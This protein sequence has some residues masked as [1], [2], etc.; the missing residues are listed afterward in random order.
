MSRFKLVASLLKQGMTEI[1]RR[2]GLSKLD[3]LTIHGRDLIWGWLQGSTLVSFPSFVFGL[4]SDLFFHRFAPELIPQLVSQGNLDQFTD[5][6]AILKCSEENALSK[7]L[8]LISVYST[9]RRIDGQKFDATNFITRELGSEKFCAI[10]KEHDLVAIAFSCLNDAADAPRLL[11]K[12]R[13]P[14]KTESLVR[15]I[16]SIG[17]NQVSLAR[18][19]W[20]ITLERLLTIYLQLDT[21]LVHVS[22]SSL[23]VMTRDLLRTLA[24]GISIQKEQAIRKL[25]LLRCLYAGQWV[26]GYLPLLLLRGLSSILLISE[27]RNLVSISRELLEVICDA[28]PGINNRIGYRTIFES[29]VI[30]IWAVRDAHTDLSTLKNALSQ[31]EYKYTHE[32]VLGLQDLMVLCDVESSSKS[33]SRLKTIIRLIHHASDVFSPGEQA[34]STEPRR[35]FI[36][37]I[38]KLMTYEMLQ[39]SGIRSALQALIPATFVPVNTAQ[40]TLLSRLDAILFLEG[41]HRRSSKQVSNHDRMRELDRQ[42]PFLSVVLASLES[43]KPKIAECAEQALSRSIA[44]D[45]LKGKLPKELLACLCRP[46]YSSACTMTSA[47]DISEIIPEDTYTLWLVGFSRVLLEHLKDDFYSRWLNLAVLDRLFGL[48]FIC[49]LAMSTLDHADCSSGKISADVASWLNDCFAQHEQVTKEHIDTS[50]HIL[51]TIRSSS[52]RPEQSDIFRDKIDYIMTAK[53]SA[54]HHRSS[55]AAMYLHISWTTSSDVIESNSTFVRA[56][57]ENLEEPDSIYGIP[58]EADIYSAL[59]G[60]EYR[61]EH[62]KTL[63]FYSSIQAADLR[64]NSEENSAANKNISSSLASL[65]LDGLNLNLRRSDGNIQESEYRSAWRLGQWTVPYTRY[66]VGPQQLLYRLLCSVSKALWRGDVESQIHLRDIRLKLY[67][68]LFSKS[69]QPLHAAILLELEEILDQRD[70]SIQTRYSFLDTWSKRTTN[71]YAALS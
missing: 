64:R 25:S 65:G 1:A 57:H 29:A 52:L 10:L 40:A 69:Q 6:C 54:W 9:I 30:L 43:Y 22:E 19:P 42:Q 55:E 24:K 70:G 45:G 17:M 46:K 34:Y 15:S 32:D 26:A 39:C 44:M 67:S 36:D 49:R 14:I 23:L 63:S 28:V 35:I 5:L 18:K 33:S 31:S 13:W 60:A 59:R 12:T 21:G 58:T 11:T 50:L 27:A 51:K 47:R 7:Y 61:N 2:A 53:A 20:Q 68:G 3:L 8:G 4:E 38:S 66:D 48:H 41:V 37:L 71:L 56:V 62:Q 16:G